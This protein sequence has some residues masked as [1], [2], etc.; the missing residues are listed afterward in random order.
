MRASPS[1]RDGIASRLTRQEY[2]AG[3]FP[4]GDAAEARDSP[5]AR[6][7]IFGEIV[8][9]LGQKVRRKDV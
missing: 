4:G 5:V 3:N 1:P 7:A 2:C 6:V 8:L 9:C